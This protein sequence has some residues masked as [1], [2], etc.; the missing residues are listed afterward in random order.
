LGYGAKANQHYQVLFFLW[1]RKEQKKSQRERELFPQDEID[2]E[3]KK[4]ILVIGEE[5]EKRARA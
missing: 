4:K 3:R 5:G 1:G 2:R